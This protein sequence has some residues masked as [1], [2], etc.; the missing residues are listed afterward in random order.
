[1]SS[2]TYLDQK[3]P[4]PASIALDAPHVQDA[5]RKKGRTNVGNAH[6]RPE[7]TQSYRQLMVLVEV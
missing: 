5:V 6:G 4:P 1:V 2:P 7:E 3:Q